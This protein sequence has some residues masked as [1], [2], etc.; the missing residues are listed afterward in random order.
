[1]KRLIRLYPRKWRE[2]YGPELEEVVER[3]KGGIRSFV[4][5]LR[6]IVDA[7]LHP[8]L[9]TLDGAVQAT[10]GGP[11]TQLVLV[12]GVGFRG[13]DALGTAANV[14]VRQGERTC[15]VAVT[16]DRDGVR[17]EFT[18]DGLELEMPPAGWRQFDGTVRITDDAG[19]QLATRP[20]WQVGGQFRRT[21][22]GRTMLRY[23]DLLPP[24]A[25]GTRSL[26]LAVEGAAGS[27]RVQVPVAPA[28]MAGAEARAVEVSDAT[29]GIVI[30]V[31]AVARSEA[32]TAIE[33]E[34]FFDP[35]NFEGDGPARQYISALGTST[36]H[37]GRLGGAEALRLQ[38]DDGVDYREVGQPVIEPAA[39][40]H[41]E[42][43]LFGPLPQHVHVAT[44]EIPH[45]LVQERSDD[46]VTVAVPSSTDIAVTGCAAQ[47]TVSRVSDAARGPRV[48]IE[49]VPPDPDAVRQ[50]A[51]LQSV[52]TGQSPMGTIGTTFSRCAGE[53]MTVEVPDPSGELASVTLRGPVILL[54]G[55][56]RLKIPLDG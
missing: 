36:G 7:R 30:A 55:P 15:V 47:L 46:S 44:L 49:L 38:G 22:D 52:D 32:Q 43:V 51:Y 40:R 56:W 33:L 50:L 48:R 10:A 11:G 25:P 42:T 27:W 6:G 13:R 1:M 45:V 12:P 34:A 26:T 54:R 19:R 14:V 16:P 8:E 28:E 41:R 5:L 3:R 18:I 24:L 29:N 2:R 31:R 37:G 17:L 39:R 9:V 23:T 4:D 21:A 20:R 53:R 35:P